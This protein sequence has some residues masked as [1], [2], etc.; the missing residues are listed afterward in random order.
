MRGKGLGIF[1]P[2]QG[3]EGLGRDPAILNARNGR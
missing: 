3:E 2:V 1:Q